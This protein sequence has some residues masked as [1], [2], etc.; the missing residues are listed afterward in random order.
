MK[1]SITNSTHSIDYYAKILLF[2]LIPIMIINVFFSFLSIRTINQQNISRIEDSI[3]IYALSLSKELTAVDQFMYSTVVNDDAFTDLSENASYIEYYRSIGKVR[4]R[5]DAVKY[6]NSVDYTFIIQTKRTDYFTNI[7]TLHIPYAD[8]LFFKDFFQAEEQ[9]VTTPHNVWRQVK[10]TENDY[11]YRTILYKDKLIHSIVSTEYILN[12]LRQINLGNKGQISLI[13]LENDYPD[14]LSFGTNAMTFQKKETGLPFNI[15]VKVDYKNAFKNM[16]ALQVM[17]L[18]I[19]IVICTISMTILVYIQ[20]K[21]LRPVKRLTNRLIQA[22]NDN[23]ILTEGIT[24][25]DTANDQISHMVKEMQTLK[26]NLYESELTKQQIETNYLRLQVRPHFYLN[27][28]TMINSMVQTQHFQEIEAL[29]IS[30]TKYL[31]YLFQTN[32]DFT[33]LNDEL[34]HIKDYLDVQELRYGE[35]FRYSLVLVDSSL[36]EAE[37]PPLILQTFIENIFKHCFSLDQ[38]LLITVTIEYLAGTKDFYKINVED[39]GAGF[40]ED[41]LQKLRNRVSLVTDEGYHIGLTNAFERLDLLYQNNY[42]LKFYNKSNHQGAIIQ[43]IVPL[44]GGNYE[45]SFS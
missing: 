36:K 34:K 13:P 7:S 14:L 17:L 6:Y 40:S 23:S 33:S 11:L 25:I 37:I 38:N 19:P 21:V 5:T 29:T 3:N 42:N 20:R 24:E 4:A 18:L 43:L 30:T 28:L 32:Q 22:S 39:N 15:Y 31:R 12:P 35:T 27:I 9:Q 44:K 1:L 45:H 16:V 2:L 8:F 26:I 10:A 41:I